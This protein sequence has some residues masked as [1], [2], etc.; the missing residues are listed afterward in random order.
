MSHKRRGRLTRAM[1][2]RLIEQLAEGEHSPADLARAN[3]LPLI[4]L[5]RWAAEP[6]N[7]ALL[8]GLARLAD[9]RAQLLL[10]RYRA[11]A[12]VQLPQLVVADS[13]HA[14]G[15]LARRKDWGAFRA[16][17]EPGTGSAS[18][19]CS[20]LEARLRT[21]AAN[22]AWT[23]EVQ[24]LWRG[25]GRSQP[26]ACDPVFEALAARGATRIG[27]CGPGKVLT[28]LARRID[29]SL[30]ARALGTIADFDAA[31]EEWKS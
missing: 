10:G 13:L 27:E 9:V 15:E 28:G 31:L 18:L 3:D 29:K 30:D 1:S 12:A 7:I 22:A 25:A 4:R 8:G 20:E 24:A 5:A 6:S 26:D 11:S 19:A 21:G 23:A 2:D 16:A 14:L 17:W